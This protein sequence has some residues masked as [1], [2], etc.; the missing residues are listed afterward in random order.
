MIPKTIEID[1]KDFIK[2][3]GIVRIQNRFDEALH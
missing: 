2:R 1:I 3:T